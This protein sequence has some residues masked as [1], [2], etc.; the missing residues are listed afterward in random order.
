MSTTLVIMAAGLGSRYGGNKQTEGIGPNHEML[1]E[2]SLFDAVR[3]GFDK[4]VFIIK[5]EMEPLI[6]ALCGEL[7]RSC[8]TKSGRALEV[9]YAVQD[10][11]SLPSFYAVPAGRVKPFG[12]VHAAL[13]ARP[14]VNEPFAIINA[15]DY[16]GVDAFAVMHDCLSALPANEA[17]MVGYRLKNTVSEYGSVTR[18]VCT[19]KKGQLAGIKETYKIT[20][21]PDGTIRDTATDSAGVL[22]PPDALVSM[23]F[24]GYLPTIFDDMQSAFDDFLHTF[25]PDDIKSEYV[26]PSMMDQLMHAGKLRVRVLSTNAVWFGMTY[27][28]DKPLVQQSL[29][30]LHEQGVYPPTLLG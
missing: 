14:Y 30:K 26:L 13:C 6:E 10:F 12:T 25:A 17:A 9:H 4:A 27:Q 3:A 21:F 1:M 5:P 2:Y 24:W 28:Q 15:D 23:N 8:R 11:T 29:L 22:L 19:L 16:Y 7:V 20:L 18:G